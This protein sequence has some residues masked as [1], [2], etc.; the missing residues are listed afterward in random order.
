MRA[1]FLDYATVSHGGD[2]DSSRLRAVLPDLE[3]HDSTP[4]AAVNRRIAGAAVVLLNK[5]EITRPR[6]A[7]NPSLRLLALT[8]TGTNNVD[9]DAAR[10]HDVAVCN[11]TDYCTPSVV[12][13]VFAGLLALTHRL[14]DYDRALKAGAWE[15][16]DQFTLLHYPIRELAGRTFGV[17]GYGALGRGVAGIAT[18]FG[19]RV[20]VAARAFAPSAEGRVALHELLPQVDVLSLHCPVTP[21]TRGLI[22]AAELALMKTDA[23]LINTARGALV[24]ARALADALRAGRLGGAV[25]D[26]L[27]QEPPIDGNPLLAPDLANLIVTPHTAWAAHA[28]RQRALDELT[29]NVQDFLRGGRRG[30]V[31]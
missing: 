23:V 17:V 3:F 11:V 21:A 31:A 22:G 12:Q 9:L 10:E 30:R 4:D 18:A 29:A 6:I 5:A 27:E 13:H 14:R 28:S 26:V 1:V 8:A 16:A 19:M 15:S 25:I 7:A 20:L 24:D 2:L